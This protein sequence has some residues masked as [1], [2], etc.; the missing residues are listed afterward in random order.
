MGERR[1]S[2]VPRKSR[3]RRLRAGGPGREAHG[4]RV[5]AGRSRPAPHAD[6]PAEPGG[7][8]PGDAGLDDLAAEA[9][10]EA[11]EERVEVEEKAAEPQS[12]KEE[13]PE[14]SKEED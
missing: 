9:E 14:E 7:A 8:A 2:E 4:H 13:A 3:A 5:P 1:G 12:V 11:V 10:P 6:G